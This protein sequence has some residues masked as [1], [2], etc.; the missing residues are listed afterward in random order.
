MMIR[1]SASIEPS[2]PAQQ[3]SVDLEVP[4]WHERSTGTT[5]PAGQLGEDE[6]MNSHVS[7][8]HRGTIEKLFSH[9]AGGNVEW[10]QVL[11]VLE[12]LGSVTRGKDIDEQLA[13]DVRRILRQ[14]RL[15]AGARLAAVGVRVA[16]EHGDRRGGAIGDG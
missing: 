1:L 2:I 3:F 8:H 14:G 10:R 5:D 4:G 12:D 16:V 15:C 9:P 13:V 7:S 6:A 11:S